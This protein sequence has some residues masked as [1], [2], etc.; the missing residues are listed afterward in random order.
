MAGAYQSIWKKLYVR[1]PLFAQERFDQAL[2]HCRADR[3]WGAA[4]VTCGHDVMVD[5]LN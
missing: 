4:T 1:P 3:S 2:E 5:Q